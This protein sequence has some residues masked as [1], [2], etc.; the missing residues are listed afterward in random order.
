M[1]N[2]TPLSTQMILFVAGVAV[3]AAYFPLFSKTMRSLPPEER[4]W[5]GKGNLNGC[6][7]MAGV[8][9]SEVKQAECCQ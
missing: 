8:Y 7:G 4:E 9:A 5:F 3:L 6:Y 1:F 2:V